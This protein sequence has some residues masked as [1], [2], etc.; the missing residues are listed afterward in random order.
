[1]H[2]PSIGVDDAAMRLKTLLLGTR[3]T[4]SGTVYGTIVVLAALTA[5]A[6]AYQNDLWRLIVIVAVT[7]LVLWAA[8]VYSDGIGES[9]RI[10]RRLTVAELAAIVRRE[11]SI[12]LAAVLP[13]VVLALGAFGLFNGRTALWIAVAIGVATLTLEGLRYARLEQMSRIATIGSVTVNL[14]LGLVIV[15]LKVLVAH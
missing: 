3:E 4:I 15:A 13:G 1:M 9:L 11:Y 10:G 12:P 5:G 8:H 2:R 6:H 14:T 7:V